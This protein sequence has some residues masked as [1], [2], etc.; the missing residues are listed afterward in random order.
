MFVYELKR[1]KNNRYK[2][3]SSTTNVC[4]THKLLYSLIRHAERLSLR[5]IRRCSP[6]ANELS[7][8]N[9][10][11]YPFDVPPLPAWW[12]RRVST[13]VV[14]QYYVSQKRKSGISIALLDPRKRVSS[15]TFPRRWKKGDGWTRLLS[16]EI[17]FEWTDDYTERDIRCARD[18]HFPGCC[19]HDLWRER[20]FW[21][22]KIFARHIILIKTFVFGWETGARI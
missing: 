20:E 14:V 5:N 21:R 18:F 8:S 11:E 10:L 6:I 16:L 9:G 7:R 3:I 13:I 15:T 4:G 2:L 22:A 1:N 17:W 12:D 19:C